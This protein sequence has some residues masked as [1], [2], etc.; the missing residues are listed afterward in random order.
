LSENAS[1]RTSATPKKPTGQI[2]DLPRF[3]RPQLI[4]E[5]IRV[6]H[7]TVSLVPRKSESTRGGRLHRVDLRRFHTGARAFQFLLGDALMRH[8]VDLLPQDLLDLFDGRAGRRFRADQERT[9]VCFRVVLEVDI[10][11]EP[12]FEKR[13]IQ[14]RRPAPREDAPQEKKRLRLP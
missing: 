3:Q 14:S 5:T 9:R 8:P 10:T 11:R 2:T 6:P 7:I 1:A 12:R 4:D 13:K